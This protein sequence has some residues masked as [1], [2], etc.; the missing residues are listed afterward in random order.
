MLAVEPDRVADD[1]VVGAEGVAGD[2]VDVDLGEG[3]ALGVGEAGDARAAQ[4]GRA[5]DGEVLLVDEERVGGS[6]GAEGRGRDY[7][8][9]T[10][11]C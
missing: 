4:V 1:L 5:A 3:G 2:E 6:A 8:A 10:S 7:P 9:G 11:V